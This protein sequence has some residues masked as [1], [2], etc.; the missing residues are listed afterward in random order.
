MFNFVVATILGFLCGAIIGSQLWLSISLLDMV[1]KGFYLDDWIFHDTLWAWFF[2]VLVGGLTGM[3]LSIFLIKRNLHISRIFIVFIVGSLLSIYLASHLERKLRPPLV[4]AAQFN[5]LSKIQ[6]AIRNSDNLNVKDIN[7]ATALMEASR[8]N[9]ITIVKA[10]IE[11]GAD[12]NAKM[13]NGRTA[14]MEAASQGHTDIVKILIDAGADINA[15]TDEG[16]TALI[17]ASIF[18]NDESVKTL[19]EAGANV[20][21]MTDSGTTA[22]M[23]ATIYNRVDSV[24][25]LREAGAI[26]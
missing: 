4:R 22:L 17:E 9:S 10:L 13:S 26:K 5:Q 15:V 3:G 24:R 16:S 6:L 2:G 25:I 14:L 12:V 8:K 20:N 19:V 23:L 7:D 18:R 21:A 1:N 11:G